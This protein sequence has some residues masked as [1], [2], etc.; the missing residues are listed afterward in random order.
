MHSSQKLH[1]GFIKKSADGQGLTFS[2]EVTIAFLS[3]QVYIT[4]NAY[5]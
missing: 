4:R 3:Y 5:S 2:I 1:T